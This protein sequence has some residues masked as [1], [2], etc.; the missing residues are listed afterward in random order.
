MSKLLIWN[1]VCV[2]CI[3]ALHPVHAQ[4][5]SIFPTYLRCEYRVDPLGIDV[6]E[7]RL[8]W[9]LQ[10]V[11]PAARALSQTAYQ[12]LVASTLEALANNQGDLWDTGKTRSDQTSNIVYQGKPLRAGMDCY[13]KARVWDQDDQVSRWSPSA[14]WSMGLFEESDWSAKWIEAP[15]RMDFDQCKWIWHPGEN[16]LLQAAAGACYFRKTF[17]LPSPASEARFILTADDQFTLYINGVK[18]AESPQTPDA[19]NQPQ[20]VEINN[21]AAGEHCLAISVKNNTVGPAG[22]TG[23]FMA[24]TDTDNVQHFILTDGGW[25]TSKTEVSGWMNPG[26]D[27]SAWKPANVL[28]Y[29]GQTN[30]P[31][32]V[33]GDDDNL[34]LTPPPYFVKDITLN[35]PVRQAM[36]YATAHGMFEIEIN[37]QKAGDEF[38]RPG[39]SDYRFRVYYNT[40]DI[41]DLLHEG[42]NS[43]TAILADGWYTGYIGWGHRRNHYEGENK[44][45]A[46]IHITYQDGTTE[47]VGTD[48]T[49]NVLADTPIREADFLHGELHD[50]RLEGRRTVWRNAVLSAK[51]THDSIQLDAYPGYSV[52]AIRELPAKKISEPSP[53]IYIY[54]IGQ[55][56]VGFVRL[57]VEGPAGTVVRLRFAERLNED[58]TLYT[59]N[60]RSAR[61]LDTYIL[62]GNGVELWQPR[63]TFHG[64]R[65]V[66][67]TGYPGHPPLDA[68]TGVVLHTELPEAGSF[69]SSNLMVNQLVHNIDWGMRGNYLELPTDCPQRDERMGWM[70]DAQVFMRTGSY[71]KDIAAFFTKW[72]RDVVDS[73]RSDGS[74]TD[75]APD[76]AGLGSGVAAWADAGVICP[77]TMYQVY[78]D[79]RIL[80]ECYQPMQ[81][82]IEYLKTNS[83]EYI[84]PEFGYGDWLSLNAD[85]P[86][87]LLATAYFAYSTRLMVEIAKALGK[88]SD[89]NEYQTLYENIRSAFIK[90]Y[91]EPDGK[92]KGNT[93]T[94]YAL[95]VDNGLIP[96]NR[97]E[98]VKY[99]LVRDLQVRD[100]HFS[101]GFCGLA[102]LFPVL[103]QLNRTDLAYRLL[104]NETFPSW[105][106]EIAQGATTIWER[107]DGW[108]PE[109]GFQDPGMNSFNHYAY[110]SVGEWLFMVSAGIDTASPGFKQIIINP[111]PGGDFRFVKAKYRS[112]NGWIG[113][114]WQDE[115]DFYAMHVSIPV[116]TSA[117]VYVK[118]RNS[119]SVREVERGNEPPATFIKFEN[120]HAI[121]EVKSGHYSFVSMK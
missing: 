120:G 119:E 108:T 94:A 25:K 62:N 61:V 99:H 60:L 118:A 112:I 93:Q 39:W 45:R 106:F 63:F 24:I 97:I 35:K 29:M 27:D 50:A 107:W 75:V 46:Q 78:G 73:Q 6:L 47:V 7:P 59:T 53:G 113:S 67:V 88:E 115:K 48:S 90:T 65:Y 110:G 9:E 17:S 72:L 8:T 98:Q 1:L 5:E 31:W 81:R 19:W 83:K 80:Q 44:L 54:D 3:G 43:I 30:T 69:T 117:M 10:A 40:Y 121:Y 28:A 87:D 86:K 57:K 41:T 37:N 22:L 11:D 33:P 76:I 71:H 77:Y 4:A 14:R 85:T 55:N 111:Q 42:M 38:F 15:F 32:G 79:L 96:E 16:A 64:F 95:A 49:W 56:M 109:F 102:E 101:T 89:A 114:E 92:L 36:L 23:K 68:V 84:R 12:I 105:G 21:L 116:N 13:W 70:G 100:Y 82:Y 26:F 103:T 104:L 91:M 66:E 20:V 51:Q 52:K 34:I 18:K 58:G 2:I 74:F